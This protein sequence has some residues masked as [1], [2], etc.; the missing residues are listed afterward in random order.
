MEHVSWK[1]HFS[2]ITE[3]ADDLRIVFLQLLMLVNDS[4]RKKWVG[5]GI[6]A[7]VF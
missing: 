3:V 2:E 6:G 5:F 7:L 1:E 4:H